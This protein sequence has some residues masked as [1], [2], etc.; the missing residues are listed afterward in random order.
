MSLGRLA[1]RCVRLISLPTVTNQLAQRHNAA[2][3]IYG[4]QNSLQDRSTPVVESVVEFR[5]GLVTEANARWIRWILLDAVIKKSVHDDG[6]ADFVDFQCQVNKLRVGLE[7]P[8]EPG[9]LQLGRQV[10][11]PV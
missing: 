6:G 11:D 5:A 10:V 3:H 9:R 1:P 2:H 7:Q 4:C 8:L